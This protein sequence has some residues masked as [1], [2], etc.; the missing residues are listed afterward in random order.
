MHDF[1]ID[2]LK[3]TACRACVLACH[4][5]HTSGFGTLKSS[6]EVYYDGENSDIDIKINN[7]CDH[8]FGEEYR[9]CVNACIP[10]ALTIG[11]F[12]ST[13]IS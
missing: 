3:C 6:I 8:C 10:K 7:T 13:N 5:H 9:F 11:S 4:F 12:E 2:L 1:I